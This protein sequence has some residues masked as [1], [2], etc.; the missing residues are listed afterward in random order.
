[1]PDYVLLSTW[2]FADEIL[3]QQEEY[4]QCRG[5]FII[6]IPEEVV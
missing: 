6:A 1:M 3:A 4:R 2:N 5:R